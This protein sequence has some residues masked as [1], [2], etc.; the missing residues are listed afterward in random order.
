MAT[1]GCAD[2]LAKIGKH[3]LFIGV[4]TNTWTLDQFTQAAQF[5]SQHGITTLI[6][7]V[8]D[9]ANG[10]T[11]GGPDEWY[12]PI[13]GYAAVVAAIQKAV[14]SMSVLPYGYLYGDSHGSVLDDEIAL[15]KKYMDTY[16]WF[17]V[18]IETEWDGHVDWATR[19][20]AALSNDSNVLY[21]SILADPQPEQN[22]GAVLQA[23]APSVN[24][25]MPQVYDDHLAGVYGQ[26]L[27]NLGLTC[28]QPTLDMSQE[29]GANNVL[30]DASTMNGASI[31]EYQFAVQNPGLLDQIVGAQPVVPLSSTGEIADFCDADQFQPSK[32]QDACGFFA[33]AIC[34]AA[35]QVGQPCKDSNST[36]INNA[37]TWYAQYNGDNSINNSFGMSLGQLYQ[38]LP[39]VGLHFQGL[40]I[41]D[42]DITNIIRAWVRAG[43]PVIIAGGEAGMFDLG[44]GDRV[45]YYWNYQSFN[46]IITVTG[47]KSDGSV[48]VRDS[49][50]VTDLNNPNSLRPGPRNYDPTR[51]QLVSATAVVLPWMPRPPAGFDPRKDVTMGVP[52]GWKDDGTTLTAPNGFKV[53]N[54]FRLKVLSYGTWPYGLPRE[55][56]VSLPSLELQNPNLGAGSRQTFDMCR[57]E[58]T[59]KMGVFVS[60]IGGEL[61]A[62]ESLRS[63]LN[64]QIATLNAT[65]AQLQASSGG[66]TPAM[67]QAIN[68]AEAAVAAL[69]TQAAALDAELKPFVK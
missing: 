64:Q 36:I 45:P 68:D 65:I 34:H 66:V 48:L 17:M 33:V 29:F 57:L 26:E 8:F 16:G 42:P 24:V 5:A 59:P 9:G 38:L 51:F 15:T 27:S 67:Q 30:A 12:G 7:K 54:G 21:A 6:V 22:Q 20:N 62:Y 1:V 18:D 43:Y 25:W 13:G 10:G 50:N 19:F 63:T 14:P 61:L 31:W 47:V 56:E 32:T 28:V 58:W 39:Q 3:S 69:Q 55:N 44:L 52:A 11:S 49:A 60:Y 40:N 41:S 23:M 2:S 53:M 35:N 4:E 37:E 46:H